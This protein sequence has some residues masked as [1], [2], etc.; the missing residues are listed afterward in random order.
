MDIP[1]Q[2]LPLARGVITASMI[3]A[4]AMARRRAENIDMIIH[5]REQH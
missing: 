2:C 5:K 3:A 1:S 4:I